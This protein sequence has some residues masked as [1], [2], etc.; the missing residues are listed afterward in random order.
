MTTAARYPAHRD[1]IGFDFAPAYAERALIR[2]S[3]KVAFLKSL[4]NVAFS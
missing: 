4:D 3:R 1:L 2:E